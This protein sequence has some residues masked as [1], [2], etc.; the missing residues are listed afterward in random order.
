MESMEARCAQVESGW[1]FAE[2]IGLYIVPLWSGA[3]GMEFS[4]EYV[5]MGISSNISLVRLVQHQLE[6]KKR[7]SQCVG[8]S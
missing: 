1:S 7:M 2:A 3:R 6:E 5:Q 4:W 8:S